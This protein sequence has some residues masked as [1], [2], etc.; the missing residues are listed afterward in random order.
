[1]AGLTFRRGGWELRY[2]E[3]S[4]VERTERFPGA[5]AKRPPEAALDRKAD[6]E[7]EL[8]RNRYVP[9]EARE[10]RFQLYFDRWWATRRVSRTRGYT[11]RSR[12]DLHVLPQWGKWR[13]CDIRPSDVD[14]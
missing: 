5:S 14:D 4:G 6:V 9:R 11:D 7:R 8:R 1:M 2:R 12:A 3:P 10:A 13:L